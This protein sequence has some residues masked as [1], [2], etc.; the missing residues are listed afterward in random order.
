MARFWPSKQKLERKSWEDQ[1]VSTM[2]PNLQTSFGK[3][4]ISQDASTS[5]VNPSLSW[6]FWPSWSVLSSLYSSFQHTL[7]KSPEFSLPIL[8]ATTSMQHTA[9]NFRRMLYKITTLWDIMMGL[10]PVELCN[11]SASSSATLIQT[12]AQG[13][14]MDRLMEKISAAGTK[15]RYFLFTGSLKVYHLRWRL[16][17]IFWGQSV[18][19]SSIGSDTQLKRKGCQIRPQSPS[20]FN[21]STQ[22]SCFCS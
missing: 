11:V 14:L 19:C 13:N 3:I 15:R 4:V 1:C 17:I 5:G 9:T 21:S 7:P 22:R 10:N 16:S 6:S 18:L 20:L 2:L 12:I 8:T